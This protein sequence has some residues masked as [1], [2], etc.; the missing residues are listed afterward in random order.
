M[1]YNQIKSYFMAKE[2]V[3]MD[4][5]YGELTDVFK[6]NGKKFGMLTSDNDIVNVFVKCNPK[7]ALALRDI[8]HSIV[9]GYQI[10]HK[11]WNVLIIDGRLP[12]VLIQ[13]QIDGSYRLLT[14]K[15]NELQ[16]A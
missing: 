9:P 14:D 15:V 8:Y 12:D 11:H 10:D 16:H 7:Q 5:P 13:Q 6:V 3:S 4:H 2:G 1:D